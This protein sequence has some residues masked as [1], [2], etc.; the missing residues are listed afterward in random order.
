VTI[1]VAF[2]APAVWQHR[3]LQAVLSGVGGVSQW[4][5]EAVGF[6]KETGEL[7]VLDDGPAEP[8]PGTAIGT[9]LSDPWALNRYG[10][11]CHAV[12]NAASVSRSPFVGHQPR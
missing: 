1:L 8:A 2:V 9:T 12:I 11:G 4:W 7:S 6:R 10:T 5:E 3:S